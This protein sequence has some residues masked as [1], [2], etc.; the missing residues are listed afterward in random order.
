[1]YVVDIPPRPRL[2]GCD[3]VCDASVYGSVVCRRVLSYY[4]ILL[5]WKALHCMIVVSY[6]HT[7]LSCN[8]C[9]RIVLG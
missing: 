5:K 3:G 1:M 4:F 6:V 8:G 9:K 7:R 2:L